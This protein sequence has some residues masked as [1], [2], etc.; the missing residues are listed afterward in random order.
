MVAEKEPNFTLEAQKDSGGRANLLK[1]RF[2]L[3]EALKE[4][5]R[6]VAGASKIGLKSQFLLKLVS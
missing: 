1:H 2:G 4:P 3:I 5:R 6:R